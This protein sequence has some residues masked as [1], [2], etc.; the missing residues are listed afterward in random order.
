MTLSEDAVRKMESGPELDALVAEH[1]MGW[2]WIEVDYSISNDPESVFFKEAKAAD[3]LIAGTLVIGPDGSLMTPSNARWFEELERQDITSVGEYWR[4][5]DGGIVGVD[6]FRF[7]TDPA[8]SAELRKKLIADGYEIRIFH[9]LD[10]PSLDSP[11]DVFLLRSQPELAGGR[12][13]AVA[14]RGEKIGKV[15][16]YFSQYLPAGSDPIAAECLCLCRAALLA[17]IAEGK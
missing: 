12:C 14:V 15:R 1:V 16:K 2:E 17:K 7:S 5:S 8:A 13:V 9:D 3:K 6:D 11:R 10:S 4:R